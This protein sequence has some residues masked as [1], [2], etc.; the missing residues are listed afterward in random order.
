[1]SSE[2]IL[3]VSL[4]Y[5]SPDSLKKLARVNRALNKASLREQ[6]IRKFGTTYQNFNP[7]FSEKKWYKLL[8][9][10]FL[11]TALGPISL[12]K[13]LY[14]KEKFSLSFCCFFNREDLLEYLSDKKSDDWFDHLTN[15]ATLQDNLETVRWIAN[16][17]NIYPDNCMVAITSERYLGC[18]RVCSW[19]DTIKRKVPKLL[20]ETVLMGHGF[21]HLNFVGDMMSARSAIRG[22]VGR[23][24]PL[25]QRSLVP[26]LMNMDF[27]GDGD[28]DVD[29]IQVVPTVKKSI[30]LNKPN[31][32]KKDLR[33]IQKNKKLPK[34]KPQKQMKWR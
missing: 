10:D 5:L 31:L 23:I 20:I 27:D 4:P 33:I 12:I 29:K 16:N 32:T 24:D 11:L 17:K 25:P 21:R 18:S 14:E 7:G 6:V 8:L 9:S 1:M 3:L 15:M 30:S 19:F 2:N 34:Q 13:V 26:N 28:G 22:T